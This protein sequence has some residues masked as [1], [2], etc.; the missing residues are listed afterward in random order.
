MPGPKRA[1]VPP[2]SASTSADGSRRIAVYPGSFD[3]ITVGHLDI[4]ERAATLFDEVV[5][6]IGTHPTKRGYFPAEERVR[7][8]E[9]A[10]EHL[11]NVR[12][13]RFGGLVVNFCREVGAR[14]IVRGLRAVAD[15]EVEFQMGLMNRDMAPEIETVFL[16]PRPELQMVSSSLVREIAGHGGDVERYVPAAVFEAIV[17]RTKDS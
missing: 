14:A 5:V 10:V 17:A 7:L 3:P 12:A 9:A 8:I 13:T 16:I 4:V 15:F 6:A 2:V 11:P 1:N